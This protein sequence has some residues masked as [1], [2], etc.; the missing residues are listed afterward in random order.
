MDLELRKTYLGATDLVAIS[1]LSPW[2]KA[3]DVWME[4][5]GRAI[6]FEGNAATELG[7]DLEPVVATR[8]ARRRQKMGEIVQ[9]GE[10]P[11]P[12]FDREFPFLAANVDRIYLNRKRVL[13][14]KTAAEQQ[15]DDARYGWGEDGETD[16]VPVYYYAQ[17]N[18]Y[19]GALEFEDAFLTAL[20]LGRQRIQ[21][22]YPIQF[23]PKLYQDMRQ[24][25]V[26]FWKTYVE[27]NV[28]PPIELF[29]PSA[30]M[31]ILAERAQPHGG[32]KG[33]PAKS[34]EYL[35]KLAEQYRAIA[36]QIDDLD[37][38]KG[39]LMGKVA[40]WIV[41]HQATKVIHRLGS[42]TY[43]QPEKKDSFEQT[44]FEAAWATLALEIQKLTGSLPGDKVLDELVKMMTLIRANHTIEVTPDP[45]KAKLHPYWKP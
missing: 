42:F 4:K 27:P 21:R 17:T 25:G 41:N 22:D 44:N 9:L 7:T 34:D 33:V 31:K 2:R 5:T 39:A 19:V 37:R 38:S 35:E 32:K 14:C 16:A 8:H 24:N 36:R 45:G 15:I 23:N 12:V 11:D 43:Q 28:Q 40:A 1:G 3:G 6:G 26:T 20:F 30:L 13:E 10:L 29:G 18:Y